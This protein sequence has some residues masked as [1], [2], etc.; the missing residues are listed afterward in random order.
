MSQTVGDLGEFGLIE[1]LA[2]ILPPIK[3]EGLIGVG[4]D[5]AVI[6]GSV[7]FPQ[8]SAGA[9]FQVSTVDSFLEDVHFTK[10]FSS[11]SDVGYKVFAVNLSDLAAMGARPVYCLV[12]LVLPSDLEIQWIEDCYRGLSE[13]AS[14]LGVYVLGGN[15]SRS[16]QIGFHLTLVGSVV[17][18]K[19]ILRSGAKVG[20]D[21]WVSGHLG[22]SHLGLQI[23]MGR[24]LVSSE[25]ADWL[26][27]HTR[28]EPRLELGVALCKRG[29]ASS[30]VDVSDGFLQDAQHLARASGIGLLVDVDSVP[31]SP[32]SLRFAD[33]KS[34]LSG[35]EDYELIFTAPVD[36]RPQVVQLGQDLSLKLSRCGVVTEYNHAVSRM[37][38]RGEA[39]E[40]S[41]DSISKDLAGWPLGYR[42]F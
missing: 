38:F 35:G 28:P 12:S 24:S 5:C 7:L 18:A 27:R 16:C 41:A 9:C 19:P 21:L 2:E 8:S 34:L 40:N 42:H 10:Q 33:L 31:V 14:S 23:L 6:P 11:P 22:F 36:L 37:N 13:A 32:E 4:D 3:H 29:L 25:A 30:A 15:I 20:H 39:G 17:G 26:S 1:R